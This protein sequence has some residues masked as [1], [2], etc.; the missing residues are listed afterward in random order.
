MLPIF[1]LLLH[2]TPLSTNTR[3]PTTV[4]LSIWKWTTETMVTW[5]QN[6][7]FSLLHYLGC[8]QIICNQ[9][10]YI[11]K[12]LLLDI[13]LRVYICLNVVI[14]PTWTQK[15]WHWLIHGVVS[16]TRYP[17]WA[18]NKRYYPTTPLITKIFNTFPIFYTQE[19]ATIVSDTGKGHHGLWREK[20]SP[21]SDRR[22]GHNG[23]W[24]QC[25]SQNWQMKNKVIF[26]KNI[27]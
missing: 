14:D 4:S 12:Y 22:K 13:T 21:W 5:Q 17:M 15:K 3:I 10:N 26:K 8:T 16:T 20:G 24:R 11:E 18:I 7:Y 6:A 9:D 19:T 25:T 2:H 23:L 1:P 27:V